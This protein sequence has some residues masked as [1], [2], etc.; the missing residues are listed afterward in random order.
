MDKKRA[1]RAAASHDGEWIVVA[2]RWL[3][4]NR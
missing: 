2:T 4:S 1:P 3:D